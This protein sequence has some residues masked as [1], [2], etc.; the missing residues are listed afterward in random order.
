MCNA[1]SSAMIEVSVEHM[2]EISRPDW[3]VGESG[4]KPESGQGDLALPPHAGFPGS[5]TAR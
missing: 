2:G 1:V 3:E 5:W 4:A